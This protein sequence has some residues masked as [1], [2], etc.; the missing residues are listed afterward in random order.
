MSDLHELSATQLVHAFRLGELSP[1][2]V[3]HDVLA[4]IARWEPHLQATWALDADARWRQAR[5]SEA[6]WQRGQPLGAGRRAGHAEGEHRHARPG[7]CRWAP[8]PPS[9]AGQ[10]A[11]APPAARLREAGCGAAGQDHDARLRHA[12]LG[13]EQLPRAAHPQPLG[14]EQEP[15]R[16]QR[17]CRAAAAAGYGPLHLGTDIGGSI[18]L[19]AAW[20]GVVGFKP[21]NGRVPIKP[22]YLGRVAGPMTRS[23]ADAAL[24]MA[25]LSQPD[26][27]DA[28]SLP[29]QPLAWADPRRDPARAARPAHRP[30]AGRR[31]GPAAGPR[32]RAPS[33]RAAAAARRAG[34]HGRAA[35]ALHHARDGRRHQ[36][37]LAHALVAG[38]LALP[39]SARPW[40]CPS[41]ATGWPPAAGFSAA[42]LF[43]GYSQF[44]A[45]RDAAVAACQPS[46]SCSRRWRPAWP[47]PPSGPCPPTTRCARWSTS[48]S[49]CPTT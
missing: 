46:T 31:L 19:P 36:P 14:P 27:R 44:A 10:A 28:T 45:L 25:T 29:A 23:V 24:L 22:P 15:R 35:G 6:R 16:Q 9:C 49:P 30:A 34:A 2:A 8:R 37:L 43:H 38:H 39:P 41:S 11:D 5:A 18:R 3:V 12:V 47:S 13:P 20:C 7:R 26:W 33:V 17:R 32:D 40:C 1:V 48:A 42:Q 21:S 4:H